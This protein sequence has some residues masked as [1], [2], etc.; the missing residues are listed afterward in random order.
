MK[1]E[2]REQLEALFERQG[3]KRWEAAA[4]TAGQRTAKLKALREAIVRRQGEFYEA[5]WGDFHKPRFEAWACEIFPTIE[6]LDE[7]IAHL[8][9]WMKDRPAGWVFFLPTTRSRSH[10]EPKG[11]VLV[12]SPWNYPFLLFVGPIISAIAAGNVVIAKPSNKTPRVSAFLASLF[13]EVFD[14]DEVAVIE[15]PGGAVGDEL[16]RLPFDHIFFTGSPS[17]GVHVGEMAQKVHAGLTLE[18][19]GKSPVVILDDVDVED[20]AKKLAWGKTLNGGQTCVAPDYALCH[21][22][23]M[24]PFA[25]AISARIRAVFGESEEERRN[26]E[27]FVHII[28][29]RAAARH[30]ALIQDALDK[31]ARRHLGGNCDPEGCYTP[32][33]ILSGVTPDMEIMQSEIFGPILPILP[34]DDLDEAISFIQ[35]RP[36]P[37]AL[38]AFG[39]SRAALDSIVARTTSGS[40]CINHNIIQIENLTVPFGGVGMSGTGNYHGIYGFRTFSHERNVMVQHRFDAVSFFFPPYHRPN[41]MRKHGKLQALAEKFLRKIKRM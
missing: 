2:S 12:M 38:Y 16:L 9:S 19:G 32:A 41:D 13:E 1:F 18:L 35:A 36:K 29:S 8:K 17:I 14:P 37:L 24:E 23:K 34:Y 10:F 15:G 31:G 22:S 4:S 30:Q 27:D 40:T 39:K 33:T 7:A 3:K 25:E 6:E 11:R 20:A 5:V 21:R 28:D 26:S